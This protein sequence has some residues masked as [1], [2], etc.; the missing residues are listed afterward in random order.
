MSFELSG[1]HCM[2]TY[3]YACISLPTGR[4]PAPVSLTP[5]Y[6]TT[7][8]TT[9]SPTTCP[10]SVVLQSW[11]VGSMCGPRQDVRFYM[12]SPPSTTHIPLI[13]HSYP[14]H[15]VLIPR[16]YCIHTALILHSYCTHT[17]LMLYSYC[18]HTPLILKG[19]SYSTHTRRTP[20]AFQV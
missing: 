14:I 19:H 8:P 15:T 17:P 12:H 4:D 5:S 20:P 6:S 3:T 13:R 7:S 11:A 18:T 10:Q 16:S 9:A 2:H 1:T